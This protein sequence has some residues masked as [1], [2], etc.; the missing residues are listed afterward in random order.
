MRINDEVIIETYIVI[1]T[2]KYLFVLSKIQILLNLFHIKD[3]P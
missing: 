3:G 1:E 2:F